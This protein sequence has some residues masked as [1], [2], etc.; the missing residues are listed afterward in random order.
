MAGQITKRGDNTWYVRIFLGRNAKGKRKYFNK[1]IHGTKKDAQKFL[2]AKLREKDL[3]VFVE[4]ASMPLYEFID[5][6][7]LEVAKH[8]VKENTFDRYQSIAKTYIKKY[9]GQTRLC[10]LEDYQVQKFYDGLRDKG[11]SPRTV[12]YAHTVLSSALKQAIKWRM[13]A[14]NPCSL[15]ELPKLKKVEMKY[16]KPN[17]ASFF[18]Q[19]AKENKLYALFLLAVETGMRPSEYLALKWT[20]INFERKFLSVKRAVVKKKGG[21]FIFSE[22]KTSNSRRSIPLSDEALNA[23]KRHRIPQLENRLKLGAD[24]QN[25]NLIFPSEVG[26]PIQHRNIVGRY[27][28]PILKKAGLP[29]IRLYDLRHTMATLLL[30]AGENPKVVSERLGHASVTLTLDTYSHV[31]PNMQA[32]ATNKMRKMLYGT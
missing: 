12:R 29:D 19:V 6:W 32:D 13:I 14:N 26:S 27:F 30:S 10:D 4:P 20:D 15:C 17:E 16:L 23:L 21:G 3:G 25:L 8:R 9:I 24:Y 31:L 28:K 5:K 22:P 11:L 2:T 18:L 1:T 7:L